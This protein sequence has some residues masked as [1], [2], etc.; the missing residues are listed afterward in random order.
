MA[1]IIFDYDGTL[2]NS[3]GIYAPAFRRV[4]AWLVVNGHAPLRN[5]TDEQIGSW[6]GWSTRDMWN[7]FMPDLPDE[8]KERCAAFVGRNML[9]GIANGEA[10]LY[11]GA[12]EMLSELRASGHVLIFLSNCRHAYM[13]AHRAAFCL[14][15]FFSGFY[16]TE[17]F[18][19]APKPVVFEQICRDFGPDSPED[20]YVAVGDRFHD[21]ELAASGSMPSVGCLYGF[22]TP[23]E[24]AGATARVERLQDVPKALA[25]I[26][27]SIR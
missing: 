12:E 20:P 18:D 6:L 14:D 16:C 24:L 15:R 1:R 21:I 3:L 11:P 17:D 10:R 5:F 4:Y 27:A 25:L 8:L 19:W 7:A 23:E 22:G 26:L 9:W 2:H 13:E